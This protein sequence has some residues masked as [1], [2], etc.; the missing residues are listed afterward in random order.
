MIPHSLTHTPQKRPVVPA[1]GQ[2]LERHTNRILSRIQYGP[3]TFTDI[4]SCFNAFLICLGILCF[5]HCIF[6]WVFHYVYDSLSVGV[7]STM[8]LLRCTAA[9]SNNSAQCSCMSSCCWAFSSSS[10]LCS[11]KESSTWSTRK[12][13][14]LADCFSF[15]LMLLFKAS[16]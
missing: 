15:T 7:Y 6:A 3:H 2:H 8:A 11:D 13:N 10:L 4:H 14:R 16:F 5:E 12:K 1:M 9:L